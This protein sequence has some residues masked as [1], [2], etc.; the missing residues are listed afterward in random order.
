MD[1]DDKMMVCLQGS[2]SIDKTQT[3]VQKRTWLTK[4]NF[5]TPGIWHNDTEYCIYVN[6]CNVGVNVDELGAIMHCNVQ[7]ATVVTHNFS[8]TVSKIVTGKPLKPEETLVCK[9][10]RLCHVDKFNG[11]TDVFTG[12]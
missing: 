6:E 5:S 1:A 2:D 9:S 7:S 10:A 12:G 3:N 4:L 11:S 8:A